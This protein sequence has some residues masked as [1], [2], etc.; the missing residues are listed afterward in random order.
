[1]RVSYEDVIKRYGSVLGVDRLQLEIRDGEF[2]VLLGPSGCGKTTTLRMLAG[3][4]NVTGGNIYIGDSCVNEVPPRDRDVAMVFQSYALYPH[5]TIAENIAYPLR[6][7]RI[8]RHEIPGRVQKAG[9]LLGIGELLQR[10]PKELSGGQRQRVALARAIVRQPRVFL[11]DEPLSNLDAKLRV[12]MRGELKRLQYE[13]G[14]TTLYVTHDQA[15]AMTLAHRVAVMASG[16][17]QQF[18]TPLNIYERPANKF[19]A[20]F[21]GS[22]SMNFLD[23]TLD[24]AERKFVSPDVTLSFRSQ[25][26]SLPHG[27]AQVVLGVRPENIKLSVT[28]FEGGLPATVYVTEALGNETF[29]FLNLGKRRIVARTGSATR[30]DMENKVWISLDETKLHFFDPVSGNR[31][32]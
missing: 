2:I 1:M 9:E 3:L 12:Y 32:P 8:P 30:L 28:D 15:E 19:V 22:P 11:M 29:V 6:V 27:P 10:K 18:D 31:L 24:H 20:G 17:L 16:R 21:M 7:R 25:A 5:M 4:E 26:L 13:L 14:T 23:G